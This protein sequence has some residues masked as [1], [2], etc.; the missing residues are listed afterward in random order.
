MRHSAL[1]GLLCC[2]WALLGCP[3][4]PRDS[5]KSKV[6]ARVGKDF[7]IR[8][9]ELLAALAQHGTARIVDPG[10]RTTV[11]RA[12]LD[13]I[14]TEHL[15]LQAAEKAGITVGSDEV[16]REVRSR[17]EGYPSGT[18][19]RLLVAEQL[20][21]SE[22]KEKIRHRLVQ[23][24]FLRARLA[25]E[26]AITDE[27]LHTRFNATLKDKKVPEQVR[28]RQI[29][30]RTSEE[31]AHI[32]D[33]LQHRKITFETAA[34]RFSTAPD[35]DQGGD[36][37]WF[38]KGDMPDSFDVCFNLEKGAMSD[39]VASDYGFHIFQILDRREEHPETFEAA[40]ERVE[41]E[42]VRERQDDAY[43]KLVAELRAKA[44]ITVV[45]SGVVHV[46]SLLPPAPITPA[47]VPPEDTNARALDSLPNAIDPVPPVPGRNKVE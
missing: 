27:D 15:M 1:L 30:V 9:D 40:R 29:L 10:A 44:P 41:E 36:L 21:L 38:T 16:E 14:I 24:S 28:A 32:L 8:E 34:Q 42:L 17:A 4:D 2:C 33:L 23:D 37:G 25:Q 5:A 19:Q 35:A 3:A 18:F 22:F 47:E 11:A 12:I 13:E 45:D 43:Q 6:V 20:N 39:I 26:P 46:V 31:A 7:E